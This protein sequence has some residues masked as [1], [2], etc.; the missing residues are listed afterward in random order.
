MQSGN[1]DIQRLVVPGDLQCRD[2][3][4]MCHNSRRLCKSEERSSNFKNT[5][6]ELTKVTIMAVHL[7]KLQKIFASSHFGEG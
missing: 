1:H 7:P 2:L 4:S 6:P 5:G 3:L